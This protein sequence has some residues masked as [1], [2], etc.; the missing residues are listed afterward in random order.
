MADEGITGTTALIKATTDALVLVS[1]KVTERGEHEETR[2]GPLQIVGRLFI[3][4]ATILALASS[5]AAFFDTHQSNPQVSTE[6]HLLRWL[7]AATAI[8]SL[9]GGAVLIRHLANRHTAL[10]FSPTEYA[11]SM[12]ATL[13]AKGEPQ[14]TIP[15][16]DKSED[17]ES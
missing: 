11:G 13:I 2:S 10:L 3:A 4:Q 6:T 16:T 5:A 8:S 1:Q 15:P 14:G 7:L 17:S 12:H 9:V